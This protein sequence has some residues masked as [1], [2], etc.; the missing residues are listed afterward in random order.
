M[1]QEPT[2]WVDWHR[3]Y[4]DPDSRLSRRLAIVQRRIVQALDTAAAGEITVISM[5]A[6]QGR[7]LLPVLA[8]HPRRSDV[9]AL[10]VELDARNVAVA[11]ESLVRHALTGVE[12][13]CADAALTDNYAD[14]VP[15]D[16]ILACGIFGN[17]SLADIEHTV[18]ALPMLAAPGAT[19]IWTRYRRDDDDVTPDI[20]RWFDDAGFAEVAFDASGSETYSV[21]TNRL[22]REP[23]AFERGVRMFEFFR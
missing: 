10:L 5:C 17:I 19:V 7:D 4:D 6:G 18:R 13:S 15:A 8:A 3:P 20:R 1:T 9:R 16:L 22:V 23:R 12:L 21:G 14:Y 2:D 11:R